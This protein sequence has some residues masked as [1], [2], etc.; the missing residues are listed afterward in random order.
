ME[1]YSFPINCKSL[2]T[3]TEK[4]TKCSLE[5]SITTNIFLIL[6]TQIKS[7]RYDQYFGNELLDYDFDN[8]AVIEKAKHQFEIAIK[9]LVK[10]CEKRLE[11]VKVNVRL[12]VEDLFFDKDRK[13]SRMKKKIEI[14]VSG[15][16]NLTNRVFT[17]PP[18]VI[19]FSPATMKT[20]N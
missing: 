9:D 13:M 10:V 16:L 1:Y 6:A 18:F 7:K 5:K 14:S 8:P 17:P 11:D 12:S 2:I 4:H 19:Y 3:R 20:T 15:K